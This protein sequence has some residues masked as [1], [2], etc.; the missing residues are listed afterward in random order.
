M[1]EALAPAPAPPARGW[2]YAHIAFWVSLSAFC[3]MLNK[4]ILFYLG[5]KFPATLAVMHMASAFA[6]AA[7]VI[8]GT[9]GG[10]QHLPPQD[11]MRGPFL[12]SL[13]AIAALFGFVLVLSN[14]AFMYLSVPTIQMLKVRPTPGA[15]AGGRARACV[16]PGAARLA[17]APA[18]ARCWVGAR[19]VV[20]QG[21][22]ALRARWAHQECP[23][24]QDGGI[25]A[26]ALSWRRLHLPGLP[27]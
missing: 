20:A 11:K 3:V 19:A 4:H 26:R 6:V 2:V 7:G 5:F 8:H 22:A 21:R 25:Q 12:V 9:P 17:A 14:S 1:G 15:G 18:A 23:Y 24:R 13:G 16:G 10:R 27:L